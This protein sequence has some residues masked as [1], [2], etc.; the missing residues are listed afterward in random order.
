MAQHRHRRAGRKHAALC[1]HLQNLLKG[2]FSERVSD[3][4][5]LHMQA[6]NPALLHGWKCLHRLLGQIRAMTPAASVLLWT[7]DSTHTHTNHSRPSSVKCILSL[8]FGHDGEVEDIS[9]LFSAHSYQLISLCNEG[10]AQTDAGT[11]GNSPG[12]RSQSHL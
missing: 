8:A 12:M 9:P 2:N 1:F 7:R 4:D 10:A 5:N 11:A 3:L 6:A